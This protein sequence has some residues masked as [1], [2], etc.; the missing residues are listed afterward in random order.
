MIHAHAFGGV[1][2]HVGCDRAKTLGRVR[3]SVQA[4]NARFYITLS[5]RL[6][7]DGGMGL[8]DAA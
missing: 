4:Y 6:S 2:A 5:D 7:E 1:R 3:S 8:L